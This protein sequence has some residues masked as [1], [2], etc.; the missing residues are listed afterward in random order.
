[1]NPALTDAC[2]EARERFAARVPAPR[3]E[4]FPCR[5]CGAP[6]GRPCVMRVSGRTGPHRPREDRWRRAHDAWQAA[7]ERACDDAVNVLC[8]LAL[9]LGADT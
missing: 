3:P 2:A 6:V 1:M 7:R 8:E 4:D 9:T 5:W